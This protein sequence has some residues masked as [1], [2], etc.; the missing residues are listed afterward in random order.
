MCCV[1]LY[2]TRSTT[3]PSMCC[4]GDTSTLERSAVWGSSLTGSCKSPSHRQFRSVTDRYLRA[5]P[6]SHNFCKEVSTLFFSLCTAPF[7][8]FPFP[9]STNCFLPKSCRTD[10]F[11]HIYPFFS[12]ISFGVFSP[13][14][15]S[16]FFLLCRWPL[17]FNFVLE[18]FTPSQQEPR[19]FARGSILYDMYIHTSWLL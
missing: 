9:F 17:R 7:P 13:H 2:N 5:P 11:L 12:L 15:L 8:F 10:P 14:F 1:S 18:H 6:S 19:S 4:L 16:A 3:P